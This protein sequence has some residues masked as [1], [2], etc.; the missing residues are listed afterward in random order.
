MVRELMWPCLVPPRGRNPGPFVVVRLQG[1]MPRPA[2][3]SLRRQDKTTYN[4]L[5]HAKVS[6]NA[7]FENVRTRLEARR[8]A[9]AMPRPLLQ[10]PFF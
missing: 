8:A 5:S 2:L 9:A 7:L 10:P 3:A 4:L 6:V 1:R